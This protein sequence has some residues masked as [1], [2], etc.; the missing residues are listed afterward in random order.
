MLQELGAIP[1]LVKDIHF[2]HHHF[3]HSGLTKNDEF[4]S[5]FSFVLGPHA[6][7][8]YCIN[9]QFS[10]HHHASGTVIS[11]LTP[12]GHHSRFNTH[13]WGGQRPRPPTSGEGGIRTHEAV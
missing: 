2:N 11:F 4:E 12:P 7:R 8:H 3:L 9:G 13:R 10:S 5:C 6:E 1:I